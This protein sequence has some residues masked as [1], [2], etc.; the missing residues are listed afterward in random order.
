MILEMTVIEMHREEL[1]CLEGS[2]V[3]FSRVERSVRVNTNTIET[4]SATQEGLLK[5]R[6]MSGKVYFLTED[7]FEKE[8]L[9]NEKHS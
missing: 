8:R 3:R 2:D 1:S 7:A 6:F 4:I 5:T 9:I